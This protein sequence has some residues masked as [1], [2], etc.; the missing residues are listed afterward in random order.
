MEYMGQPLKRREDFRFVR[1]KGRYV[2]DI[3]L[4]GM[5]WCAFVRS[6]HAHARITGVDTLSAGRLPGVLKILTHEDWL[7]AGLGELKVVHPMAFGDGRPMNEA[8]RPAFASDKVRH[9]GDVVAAVIAETRAQA[10]DA[11]ETV[12]V[13]YDVLPAVTNI[14][15]ALDGNAPIIH[16]QFGNNTV[17]EIEKGDLAATEAAMTAADHV[18][19]MTLPS[20]RVA[21]SPMEPRS[22]LCDFNP[23]NDQYTFYATC[24]TPHYLRR[25]LAVHTLFVPEHKI[26][27]IAPD[28]GGGFGLKVHYSVEAPTVAWAAGFL[29]RPVKWTA[30][31]SE[32]LLSDSQARDHHTVAKMGFSKDGEILALQ[33]DTIAALGGYLSNF[34]PS[35]PGNSYPQTLTGLYRTPIAHLRVRGAYTNTLPIDAYRGSGRPEATWVNERLTE[36]GARE[37][38]VDVTE[39]RHRNLIG[40]EEFPFPTPGGRTYDSGN[41][42]LLFEK[43]LQLA[44]YESLRA[45][46]AKLRTQ[47]SLMGIGISCF[48]DKSGTG[49]SA[50]LG[51]RGAM[52]GGY[53]S[54][55]VRVHSDGKVTLFSG[56]HS[57]G[58]GHDITFSQIAADRLGI[59]IDDIVLIEGD[60]DMVPFGNGTW[61]S[62][63][64]TVG[65]SAIMIAA[66]KVAARARRIAAH[67]LECADEDLDY[68]G[69][70]WRVRG[71]DRVVT[72]REVA[73]NAYQG[74]MLPTNND[75]TV[76][77]GLEETVFWE[78]LDTNDPQAMHLAVVV[79]DPDT[80]K[81]T[82]SNYFTSDDCGVIINPMIVE[83][84][85]HGG[86]G[87]GIGQALM[88]NVVYDH[89]GTGQ[90]LSGSFVDYCMPRADDL[91]SFKLTFIETPAPSNPLGVKGGS[92]SGTIGAPAAI[93][94]AVVDALW[95]LGV[96][97]VPLPITSQN[98]W[99]A[100]KHAKQ[101]G[102]SL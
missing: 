88:E 66:D 75:G 7:N 16:E 31:R 34:A 21:G 5:V 84:Q 8:P 94:N 13:S 70:T 10:E 53:E 93:G 74:A 6:P 86:L 101:K 43:L 20:N 76:T 51:S 100:M 80:G 82:L 64:L 60:T 78:P 42:P 62:R 35:I 37:L 67:M 30:T 33:V 39:I 26:R 54:A 4:A 68:N 69:K 19:E 91:P 83:G 50:N 22:Y 97:H 3:K 56:S 27:V 79:V 55:I 40:P 48:L 49:N 73:D 45:E 65:G 81:V 1:G 25:W 90:L 99:Q 96:R 11:V 89:G 52:H 85:V 32:S 9:V 29:G 59:D 41:P 71:T 46:Q 2:D 12:N 63:S 72:F 77:P 24:Q 95:H 44:N 47:G 17:F 28:V 87:Q 102:I 36:Q 38:G 15:R 18:V 57:H 14:S 23:D 58:Q 92:E 98:V 61:G